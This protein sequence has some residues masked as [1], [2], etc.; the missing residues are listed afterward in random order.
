MSNLKIPHDQ[1]QPEAETEC[2]HEH[3]DALLEQY[4]SKQ[5]S[6]R[7]LLGALVASA[8]SISM[9]PVPGQAPAA[10]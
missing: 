6:R 10:A 3:F 7:Q 5:L 4:E 2:R 8:A 1:N 9:T